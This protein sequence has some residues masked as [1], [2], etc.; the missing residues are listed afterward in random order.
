MNV[1][2]IKINIM[3]NSRGFLVLKTLYE[4]LYFL[5]TFGRLF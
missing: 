4:T 5:H 1:Y 3:E 2:H